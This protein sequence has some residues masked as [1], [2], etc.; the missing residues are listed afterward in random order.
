MTSH[1]AHVSLLPYR[2]VTVN[3]DA[4]RALFYIFAEAPQAPAAAAGAENKELPLL[5]WLNGWVRGRVGYGAVI[6]GVRQQPA[7]VSHRHPGSLS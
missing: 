4:G 3:D 5:L 6:S 1:A 2:Y 7:W